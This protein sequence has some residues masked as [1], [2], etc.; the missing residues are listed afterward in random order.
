MPRVWLITGASTGF[1]RAAAEE[2]LSH[3][4][5][6]VAAVRTP[7]SLRDLSSKY[8]AHR[9]LVIK[10]D[11][12]LPADIKSTFDKA[13]E[14]FGRVDVVFN[15]AGV[16]VVAE[17]EVEQDDLARK[18]FEVNFWGAANV[19]KEAVKSF[20]ERNS[21]GAGGRI[22]N[23]SSAAGFFAGP[24]VSYYTA[25]KHALEGFA[26]TLTK[27]LDPTWNIKITNIQ[28]GFFKTGVHDGRIPTLDPHPA[29]SA[30]PNS[31]VAQSR[32]VFAEADTQVSFGDPKKAVQKVYELSLLEEPPMWLPLGK[33][34][35]G[36]I[37]GQV[38]EVGR[39]VRSYASWSDDLLLIE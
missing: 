17:A 13:Y 19:M 21:P 9:L 33:D 23:N 35:V 32:K 39:V 36:L 27:E 38:E 37:L 31:P 22:V 26:E 10:C 7:S 16:G 24:I 11:V 18:M 6:V 28:P 12:T 29:Y 15:N 30:N 34:S 2:A 25:S 4:E 14:R 20:R 5:L 1:G 8:P 3:D